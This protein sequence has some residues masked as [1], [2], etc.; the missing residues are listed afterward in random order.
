MNL[1]KVDE[2]AEDAR[3]AVKADPAYVKGHWRLGQALGARGDHAGAVEAFDAGLEREPGN[4]ALKKEREKAEA[5]RE[6]E[7]LK[8]AEAPPPIVEQKKKEAPKA[9]PAA[10]K[11]KAP[12]AATAKPA[13]TQKQIDDEAAFSRSDHVRGYKL[14][15]DGKK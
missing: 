7:E 12:A 6:Q 2:A 15:K 4:K 3:E 13:K 14:N 11:A 9:K 1:G 10:A 8:E 5:K